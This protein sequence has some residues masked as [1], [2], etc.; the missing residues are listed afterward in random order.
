MILD[1]MSRVCPEAFNDRGKKK[2]V[3]KRGEKKKKNV[4][5]GVC[6]EKIK[7]SLL[8]DYFRVQP[9]RKYMNRM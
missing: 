2:D 4:K 3:E 7:N 6:T 9:E 8:G 5:M 1:N